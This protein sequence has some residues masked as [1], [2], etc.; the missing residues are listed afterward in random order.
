MVCIYRVVKRISHFVYVIFML[1]FLM[2]SR[3]TCQNINFAILHIQSTE[4]Y[5]E[6]EIN[7]FL[8]NGLSGFNM[9]F[10]T[11]FFNY[12]TTFEGLEHLNTIFSD[13]WVDAIIASSPYEFLN[14]L[15][16]FANQYK[17]LL[18]LNNNDFPILDGSRIIFMHSG[19]KLSS[20]AVTEFLKWFQWSNIAVLVTEEVYWE[21]MAV[22]VENDLL[23][24]GFSIKH[25]KT[26]TNLTE[27]N[28]F[29]NVFGDITTDE[30]AIILAMEHTGIEL[31][32]PE[33]NKWT[34]KEK[35]SFFIVSRDP[36]KSIDYII[37]TFITLPNVSRVLESCFVILPIVPNIFIKQTFTNY[38]NSFSDI[39]SIIAQGY[40]KSLQYGSTVFDS[41]SITYHIKTSTFL[42]ENRTLKF[43]PLGDE[44]YFDFGLYDYDPVTHTF[45]LSRY[46]TFNNDGSWEH[47]SVKDILWPGNNVLQP[48]KCFNDGS[49]STSSGMNLVLAVASPLGAVAL[50]VTIGLIIFFLWRK[51]ADRLMTKGPNKIIFE[52]SDL[53]FL[54]RKKLKSAKLDNLSQRGGVFVDKPDIV[55][56]SEKANNRS[57]VSLHELSEF[58]E[59]A[60][61]KGDIVYVKEISTKGFEVSG[62]MMAQFRTLREIRH[63]NVNPMYGILIDPTCYAVVSEYCNRGSLQDVIK[64]ANIKLDWDF[65]VSLLTDLVRGLRFIQ[66]SAVRYHGNLKSRNCVIDSRW[67]L[68]LTDFGLKEKFRANIEPELADLLWTAPE[69]LREP[70]FCMKGSEKGDMY[71]FAIVTQELILR[72]SPFGMVDLKREEIIKKLKK[73]PPLLR[74]SVSPQAAPPQYI[75]L[76]KSCWAE[77][78]DLRPSIEEVYHQYKTISGGKKLNIVDSMFRM[79]EKYSNDL[80]DIVKERT[81]ELE[82]EKK[83]TDLLLFRMLPPTVAESLKTGRSVEAEMFTECTIYFSDIVGFTTISA[84]SNPLQVV[85]LLNDL[86]TMFDSTIDNY[87]VYKVETI[88]DA[89][90][91]ASGL[92]IPNGNRH[93]GEIGTMALD[94]LSQCGKFTIRHMPEVPLRL[95]IGLHSGPC[96]AGVVGLTMPRYCLFGDTV[97]TASRMES[98]GA[99]F[100]IHIS[101]TTK[102]KLDE[103]GSYKMSYRGEVELKGKGLAKTFWLIGK[104]G[105]NKPLP[106][107]PPLDRLESV[108]S[109]G[110]RTSTKIKTVKEQRLVKSNSEEANHNI[111]SKDNSIKHN[112]EQSNHEEEALH[113]SLVKKEDVQINNITTMPPGKGILNGAMDD[114]PDQPN[115]G[116]VSNLSCDN[117]FSQ[118]SVDSIQNNREDKVFRNCSSDSSITTKVSV[119][120]V[121]SIVSSSDCELRFLKSSRSSK[122]ESNSPLSPVSEV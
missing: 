107:P 13:T 88:G 60:R 81:L 32:L 95:R 40:K 7:S 33:I 109:K 21:H 55:K 54:H 77:N 84:M 4:V 61:Y 75:Q 69:H 49:C 119:M 5:T 1:A 23:K 78:P 6:F 63:E 8:G 39:S 46:L 56:G 9:T 80:E 86:Y 73:P 22:S 48:D 117:L 52:L 51:H 42:N 92:P 47:I 70:G 29:N 85:T 115:D 112:V 41:A 72:M 83:K 66:N 2:T 114:T 79:L 64:S 3:N 19:F 122:D 38:N 120:S 93:A 28:L 71:S 67:V 116:T 45:K 87:D 27:S 58:S 97:N 101:H 104:D 102:V 34:E 10:S 57:M 18:I 59:I 99:A 110:T 90:M 25:S 37:S 121:D 108:L 111:K 14:I 89:Y 12:S 53:T 44:R 98:T 30:K 26:I 113:N 68:K 103:L 65:K 96:V 17:K 24:S 106:E 36:Y 16:D 74:P 11:R 20:S 31:I 35:H 105:F 62:K 100:R 15:S 82:E 43:M 91:V 118:E 94:L 50:A 76:M